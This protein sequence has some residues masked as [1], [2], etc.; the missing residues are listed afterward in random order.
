MKKILPKPKLLPIRINVVIEQKGNLKVE[1]I[2]VKPF[3]NINDLL[4]VLE[5]YF[6]M[7]LDPVLD[8]NKGAIQFLL[9]GPLRVGVADDIFSQKLPEGDEPMEIDQVD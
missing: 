7:R 1:N 9:I 6:Q 3:E 8:W 4:K 2:H 5:E